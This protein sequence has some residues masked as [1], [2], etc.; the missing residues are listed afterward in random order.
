MEYSE[1]NITFFKKIFDEVVTDFGTKNE[2]T[3]KAYAQ[4][5]DY[6]DRK[7]NAFDVP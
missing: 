2:L 6:F 3:D 7:R 4:L 5:L 1:D